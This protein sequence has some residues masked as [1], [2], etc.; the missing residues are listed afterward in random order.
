MYTEQILP[1]FTDPILRQTFVSKTPFFA[2]FSRLKDLHNV[3]NTWMFCTFFSINKRR[4]PSKQ[5]ER[6]ILPSASIVTLWQSWRGRESTLSPL[7]CCLDWIA[8]GQSERTDGSEREGDHRQPTMNQPGTIAFFRGGF[9]LL[10]VPDQWR[11]LVA[12]IWRASA[13]ASSEVAS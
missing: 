8:P 2:I 12:L 1:S 6:A 9:S 7:T 4:R 3:Y 13:R 5:G 10:S 11:V